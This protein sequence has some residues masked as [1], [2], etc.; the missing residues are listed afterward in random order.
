VVALLV[1]LHGFG[2]AIRTIVS[3]KM[4]AVRTIG[5]GGAGQLFLG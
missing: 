1:C 2:L 5:I 4:S 3:A